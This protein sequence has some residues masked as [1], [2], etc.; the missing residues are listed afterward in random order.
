MKIRFLILILLTVVVSGLFSS[1]SYVTR[2]VEDKGITWEEVEAKYAG[3]EK[4]DNMAGIEDFSRDLL[5]KPW[6]KWQKDFIRFKLANS[7]YIQGKYKKAL[8]VFE[9]LRDNKQFR[10]KVHLTAGNAALRLEKWDSALKWVLKVYLDL[11]KAEKVEASKIVFLSYLYSGRVNKAALWYS[12]LNEDK[13]KAVNSE[14]KE[15]SQKNPSKRKDFDNILD[16]EEGTVEQKAETEEV[17]EKAEDEIVEIEKEEESPEKEIEFD[18][19]YEP[20]WNSLCVALSTDEKWIKF[21]E[22]IKDFTNWF[23]LKYKGKEYTISYLEYSEPES[24]EKL[25]ESAK[26]KKCF[27][28][29]GPFFTDVYA[30]DFITQSEKHS[31]PVFTYNSYV[32]DSKGLVFNIKTTKDIEAQNLVKF[33]MKEKE[34]NT[35][36]LIY[37]DDVEGRKLRDIYWKTIESRGGQV[38]GIIPL[39]TDSTSYFTSIAEVVRKPDEIEDAVRTFK[40]KNK[41]S[42]STDTL[43][44]RALE[45]FMKKIPGK[46]DF[47]ALVVLTPTSEI[48]L[49]IPSFPY[50]NVEFDFYQKY[51]RRSVKLKEQ[52]VRKDGYDWHFQKLTVL[53]PSELVENHKEIER[54]GRLVDGMV[55]FASKNDFSPQNKL[56]TDFSG[57]F[58]KE[59]E[60][61]LYY[62]EKLIGE[63]LNMIAE[64]LQKSEKKDIGSLVDVLRDDSFQSLMTG[65]DVRFDAV[66]RLI[67]K[68]DIMIGR[69]KEPFM[70]PAEIQEQEKKRAE[71]RK[72]EKAPKISEGN[73]N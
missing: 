52:D 4:A 43:M 28:L 41:D 47:D 55:V 31:I 5:V 22:V 61:D 26:E 53:S 69:K 35:F 21:N 45:R 25:F 18:R 39:S 42:Y 11:Q 65:L 44:K 23:F 20:D 38:S 60:R 3:L 36:G 30:E 49:L 71:E 16:Q 37:I 17:K 24:I 48:P 40:W 56:Y 13:R 29:A 72:K 9:L 32:S 14:L 59:K 70:T 33:T 62:V 66:N 10:N 64:A 8:N 1:C 57:K 7:L 50:L 67:G 15:W 63:T 6:A 34:K 46:C 27:A 73:A 2:P 54:L 19:N 58:T 68:G 12:R 51:L